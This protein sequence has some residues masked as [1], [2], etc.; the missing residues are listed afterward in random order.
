MVIPD[1][2]DLQEI[3]E[4]IGN[5]LRLNTGSLDPLVPTPG[6]RLVGATGVS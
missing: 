1:N 2:L 5:E 4:N 3:K 6:T